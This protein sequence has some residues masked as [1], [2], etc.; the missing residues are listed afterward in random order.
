MHFIF[1]R[2]MAFSRTHENATSS[3]F[4]TIAFAMEYCSLRIIAVLE[5]LI[6]ERL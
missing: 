2:L 1:R 5:N 4:L 6:K 3:A